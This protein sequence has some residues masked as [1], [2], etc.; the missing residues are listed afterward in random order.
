MDDEFYKIFNPFCFS[1][2]APILVDG[3]NGI[4]YLLQYKIAH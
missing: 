2:D 1:P 3:V 4:L